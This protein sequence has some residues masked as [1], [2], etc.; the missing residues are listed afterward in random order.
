LSAKPILD[1]VIVVGSKQEFEKVKKALE[2]IHYAH[3]GDQGI[4]DREVFKLTKP[5]DFFSHHLYVA[6]RD[7]L[8]LK[9]QLTFRDH[10]REHSED[11]QRYGDLKKELAKRF[12][13]DM[14][15]YIE[16]KTEFI[17]SILKQ[18]HFD[19]DELKEIRNINKK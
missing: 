1:I 12:P 14:G 15:S 10:L 13:D 3:V 8:G 16:G 18:Y 19:E 7:S 11:V 2:N 5:G 4:K 9:N 6:L 17:I